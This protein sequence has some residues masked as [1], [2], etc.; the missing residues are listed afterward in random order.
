VNQEIAKFIDSLESAGS[1]PHT[2]RNYGIDLKELADF[3]HSKPISR[4]SKRDLRDFLGS[5]MRW[6][7]DRSSISRKL[8]STRSFFKFLKAR[9]IIEHNPTASLSAPK[10]DHKLP[11]FLT[12][13]AAEKLMNLRD[14]C[15]RDRAILEL[16]YG[17]GIRASELTGLNIGN[18]NYIDETIKVLGKRGRERII[19]LTGSSQTALKEYLLERGSPQDRS[20]PLFLNK[21]KERLSQRSLQRIVNKHIRKVAELARMSPHTLRHT[22]A[23]HLLEKGCDLR[24]V[25]ELLGH[26]SIASTQIYTHL[27]PEKLKK[28]YLQA[29]PRASRT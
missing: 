27:T 11:S 20:L 15:A 28:A 26:R 14:L 23:T 3:L 22:F 2:I 29:H 17:A 25:Q 24:T 16:L 5:L 7:Y 19:P 21:Y 4:V 8:S 9:G 12:Q 13:D 6:G 1:S 18:V 10:L